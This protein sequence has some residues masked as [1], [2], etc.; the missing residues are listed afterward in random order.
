VEV[1]NWI[2]EG[3]AAGAIVGYVAG[4]AGRFPSGLER[5]IWTG[6]LGSAGLGSVFGTCGYLVWRYGVKGGRLE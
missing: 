5:R 3:A 6:T 2:L 1:D 4:R